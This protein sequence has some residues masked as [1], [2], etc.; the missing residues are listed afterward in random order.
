M[1]ISRDCFVSGGLV[2]YITATHAQ[3]LAV[4]GKP[5]LSASDK[6]TCEWSFKCYDGTEVSVYDWKEADTPRDRYDWHVGG[7]GPAALDALR[8]VTGGQFPIRSL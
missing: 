3:L 4:L 2:G 7:S 1:V 6:T 8:R 5:N